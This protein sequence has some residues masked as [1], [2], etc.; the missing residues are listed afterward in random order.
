MI[1]DM[2]SSTFYQYTSQFYVRAVNLSSKRVDFA[3]YK[4]EHYQHQETDPYT[5]DCNN[6]VV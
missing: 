6:I 2:S 1:R 4:N 5:I 3:T